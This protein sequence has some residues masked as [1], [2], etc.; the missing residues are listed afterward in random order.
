MMKHIKKKKKG[1]GIKKETEEER[2]RRQNV[3]NLVG[4]VENIYIN[5]SENM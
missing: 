4:G 1:G 2:D 3:N 5:K